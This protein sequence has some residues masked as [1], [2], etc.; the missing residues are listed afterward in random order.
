MVPAA[1]AALDSVAGPGALIRDRAKLC[2]AIRLSELPDSE[3]LAALV[4]A[5]PDRVPRLA[6][7]IARQSK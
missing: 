4:A 5:Q 6:A 3:A 1:L 7:V 2:D